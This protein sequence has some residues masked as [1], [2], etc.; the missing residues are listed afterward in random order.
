M[1]RTYKY[2]GMRPAA[3][4]ATKANKPAA[5]TVNAI[6]SIYCVLEDVCRVFTCKK[7][8]GT[9]RPDATYRRRIPLTLAQLRIHN[10]YFAIYGKYY[11]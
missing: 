4:A 9:K 1:K 6:Y 3:P 7:K 10:Q 5:G 8:I 2:L 11:I